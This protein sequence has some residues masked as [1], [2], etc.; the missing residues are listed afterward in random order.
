MFMF[1]RTSCLGMLQLVCKSQAAWQIVFGRW[2]ERSVFV[3]DEQE[4]DLFASFFEQ[5]LEQHP[6]MFSASKM[7]VG[8]H[9]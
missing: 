9:S 3:L 8:K 5:V 4:T 1:V 7:L 6:N 2:S